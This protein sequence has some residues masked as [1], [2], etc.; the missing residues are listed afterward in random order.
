MMCA[1][2]DTLLAIALVL[3]TSGTAQAQ[4][5]VGDWQGSLNVGAVTLRLAFHITGAN[6][7]LKATLDSLDQNAK[8]LPVT[9]VSLNGSTL[10]MELRQLQGSFAGTIDAASE[11]IDGTWTQPGGTLTLVLTRV[12][13]AAALEP[14]RPQN[15]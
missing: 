12:K 14:R 1:V 10:K 7:D 5:A 4:N 13:N 6:D 15:P 2:N 11:K 9:S 8:G 3:L